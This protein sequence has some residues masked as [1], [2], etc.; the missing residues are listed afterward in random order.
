LSD[1]VGDHDK[2]SNPYGDDFDYAKAFASVD[3][4]ELKADIEKV[5]KTSQDWWPADWVTTAG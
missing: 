2:K 1:A 5:L 3:L 4:K